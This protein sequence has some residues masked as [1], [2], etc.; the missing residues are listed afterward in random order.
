M[1]PLAEKM[2]ALHHA[3]SEGRVR[4]GKKGGIAAA[5]WDNKLTGRD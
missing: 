3:F 2:S 5:L 1:V 4:N